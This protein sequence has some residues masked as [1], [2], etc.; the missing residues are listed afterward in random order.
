MYE[1]QKD[2]LI[3]CSKVKW[4]SDADFEEP[5]QVN[6]KISGIRKD[7]LDYDLW[8]VYFSIRLMAN[9]TCFLIFVAEV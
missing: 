4:R 2:C 3:A 9:F 7:G 8:C 6:Q 5:M 1:P